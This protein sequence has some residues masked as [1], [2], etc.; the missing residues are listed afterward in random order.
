MNGVIEC[1]KVAKLFPYSLYGIALTLPNED[2]YKVN[3]RTS[4]RCVQWTGSNTNVIVLKGGIDSD[5]NTYYIKLLAYLSKKS[6]IFAVQKDLLFDKYHI[7]D[8]H[9]CVQFLKGKFGGKV[10]LVGFSVGGFVLFNYISSRY[11][12]VDRY[13]PI[14]CTFDMRLFKRVVKENLVF[15]TMSR[16]QLKKYSCT[17][18]DFDY[19]VGYDLNRCSDCILES[20]N[21][22]DWW[23]EKTYYIYSKDDP[24]TRDNDS[25]LNRFNILPHIHVTDDWHCGLKSIT[26]CV[27]L[28]DEL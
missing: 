5:V 18:D 12:D 7:E 2:E 25:M 26:K 9:E 24:F 21:E 6:N 3:E 4:L 13:I 22:S 10:A 16:R 15:R 19:V 8:I 17:I 23:Q 27:E 28:I 14:C 11:N 20:L 1:L